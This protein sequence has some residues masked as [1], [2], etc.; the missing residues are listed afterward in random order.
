[1]SIAKN[2]TYTSDKIIQE[3]VYILSNISEREML[4]EITEFARLSLMLNETTDCVVSDNL[5]IAIRG[6]YTHT[7]TESLN[8]PTCILK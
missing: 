6:Q 3:M 1:M 8:Q 4:N 5:Q 7:A 2:A